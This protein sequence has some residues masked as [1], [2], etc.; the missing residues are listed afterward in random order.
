MAARLAY[1]DSSAFVKLIVAEPESEAL[2]QALRRWPER[3]SATLLRTETVRALRRSGNA[4][5]VAQARRLLRSVHMI[6]IDEPLLDR[7]GELDPPDLRSLDALHL[8]AA[9]G[10]ST[11]VGIMFVYD[12][13]LRHAAEACGLE[14]ASPA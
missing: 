5:Y 7:A 3:V 8:A 9:L 13:R 12:S 14:V 11:E 4:Q 1:V 10:L 6:R 2:K